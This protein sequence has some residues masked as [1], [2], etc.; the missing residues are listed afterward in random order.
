VRTTQIFVLRLL[1]D[2][3]QPD[4]LHGVLR[5]VADDTEQSFTDEAMLIAALRHWMNRSVPSSITTSS[6]GETHEP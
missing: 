1:V 6:T 3:D 4:L 2:A 5:R